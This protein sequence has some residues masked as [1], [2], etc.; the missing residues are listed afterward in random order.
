MTELFERLVDLLRRG[1]TVAMACV[2]STSGS[3]PAF[4]G[5][6]MLVTSEGEVYSTIGGG[7]FESAVMEDARKAIESGGNFVKEYDLSG[8][9]PDSVGMACGGRAKVAIEVLNPV[10]RLLVFG[11]GHVGRAVAETAGGLG[12]AVS[13]I[14]DRSEYLSPEDF[15]AGTALKLT[16]PQYDRDIP[17]VDANTFVVIATRSHESDLNALRGVIDRGAAYVGMIGSRAKVKKIFSALGAEGVRTEALEKVHAP[18]GLK[19]GSKT[20]KEIAISI[21]AEVVRVRNADG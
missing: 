19:I 3:T 17:G 18:I 7:P 9:G 21:L 16:T 10:Q 1:E 8:K 12:F 5:A 15:P 14:D 6:R 2:L 13:V 4:S 20:P 11:A